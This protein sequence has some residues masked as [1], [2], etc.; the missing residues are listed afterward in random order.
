MLEQFLFRHIRQLKVQKT[1]H[2]EVLLRDG[3]RL[4]L[5]NKADVNDKNWGLLVWLP[6]NKYQYIPWNKLSSILLE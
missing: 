5:G 1:N 2:T 6:K 4:I 3:K